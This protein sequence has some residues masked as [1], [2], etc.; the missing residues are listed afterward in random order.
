MT[1]TRAR[2]IINTA[3]KRTVKGEHWGHHLDVT[4]FDELCH[5]KRMMVEL[6]GG[7]FTVALA[8]IAYPMEKV[9]YENQ[10]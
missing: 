1:P 3:K 4:D 5:I 9:R 2:E 8:V 7:T 10:N 6:G